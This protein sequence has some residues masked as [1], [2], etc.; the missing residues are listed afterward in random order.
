MYEDVFKWNV[1]PNETCTVSAM[2][3]SDF[4]RDRCLT[5]FSLRESFVPPLRVCFFFFFFSGTLTVAFSAIAFSFS[6]L[7][8][9]VFFSSSFCVQFVFLYWERERERENHNECKQSL[10]IRANV[11]EWNLIS[12]CTKQQ[13]L[14][15][16]RTRKSQPLDSELYTLHSFSTYQQAA[17]VYLRLYVISSSDCHS[18]DTGT[19]AKKKRLFDWQVL[20]VT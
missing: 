17:L 1:L 6:L 12:T 20:R 15:T 7:I 8:S 9:C 2:I 5:R 18:D 11:N 3:K 4:Y 10:S 14:I 19:F 13:I 16:I